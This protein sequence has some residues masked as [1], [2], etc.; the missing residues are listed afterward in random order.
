MIT[1][2]FL[3]LLVNMIWPLLVSVALSITC[4]DYEC[5]G[6]TSDI[7]AVKDSSSLTYI[8]DN[9][10]DCKFLMSE[11]TST[12]SK[13][14]GYQHKCVSTSSAY[15]SS[16]DT[17]QFAAEYSNYNCGDRKTGTDFIESD[18]F[19][20]KCNDNNDCK[21]EDGSLASCR[22]ALDGESYCTPTL[23][24]TFYD[25]YWEACSSS[26]GLM[27]GYWAMI[28]EAYP[29]MFNAPDCASL[30]VY[31]LATSNQIGAIFETMYIM[32]DSTDDFAISLLPLVLAW[33]A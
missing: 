25:G 30:T 20:I 3:A 16:I 14:S 23:S 28:Y 8:N 11:L 17:D 2:R 18:S 26:D 19:P 31:E 29:E 7:C 13:D 4:G 15:N 6:L 10:C 22:C 32:D 24:S 5:K 12:A 33:L 9:G 1:T 21:L 27:I